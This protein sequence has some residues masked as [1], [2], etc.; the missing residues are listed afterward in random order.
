MAN[1]IFE[2]AP[3][4]SVV[5]IPVGTARALGDKSTCISLAYE[6]C[7]VPAGESSS[8]LV[9]TEIVRSAD[10]LYCLSGVYRNEPRFE[11]RDRS[12]I[13]YGAVWLKI[14]EEPP[15][16]A[17]SITGPIAKPRVNWN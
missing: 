8:E 4:V 6:V 7:S 9:G 12:P 10:G 1:R 5:G 3:P 14:I 11:V 15:K 16:S 17:W 2:P 13:H